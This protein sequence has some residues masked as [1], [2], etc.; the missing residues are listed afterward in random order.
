MGR[1]KLSGAVTG[2]R[3]PE[4]VPVERIAFTKARGEGELGILKKRQQVVSGAG[5][6]CAREGKDELGATIGLVG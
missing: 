1:V 2:G 5:S 4:K 6:S 3:G